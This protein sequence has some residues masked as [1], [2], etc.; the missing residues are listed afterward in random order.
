MAL[1]RCG[2]SGS[3]PWCDGTHSANGFTG[4]KDPQRVPDR[5]DSYTGV[6]VTVFDSAVSASIPGCTDRLATVFHAGSAPF[7]TPS[8]GRMDE[9]I[10]QC[11]AA[12]PGR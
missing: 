12:R 2:D 4:A 9:I 11:G 8:G 7:V 1:C 10:G 3:K 6:Q 5:R